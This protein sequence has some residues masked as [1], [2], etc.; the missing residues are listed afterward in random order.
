MS[1]SAIVLCFFPTIFLAFKHFYH[2]PT[3]ATTNSTL[4][5]QQINEILEK[6]KNQ[7][8]NAL[9]HHN[10]TTL[11]LGHAEG[12]ASVLLPQ[13]LVLCTRE[14]PILCLLLM[15]GT[16]WLGYA[17]YLIKRRYSSRSKPFN[18][19]YTRIYAG[20]VLFHSASLNFTLIK[21]VHKELTVFHWN[22]NSSIKVSWTKCS[23]LAFH[24]TLHLSHNKLKL[25]NQILFNLARQTE[26]FRTYPGALKSIWII[27]CKQVLILVCVNFT[28]LLTKRSDTKR[29]Y[30]CTNREIKG[31]KVLIMLKNL[32]KHNDMTKSHQHAFFPR[33]FHSAPR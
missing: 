17:L 13:S 24:K 26:S 7:A 15:L 4:V 30:R 9:E 27:W 23:P 16:L 2:G 5:L 25:C 1:L 20:T 8:A 31:T 11:L 18:P 32:Q 12:H 19:N 22:F 28:L 29:T 10:E 21:T 3:L 14:R 33:H 6:T